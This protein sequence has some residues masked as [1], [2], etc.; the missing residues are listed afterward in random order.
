MRIHHF[1]PIAVFSLVAVLNAKKT[2]ETVEQKLRWARETIDT[3]A[4]THQFEP[5]AK[6]SDTKWQV[7][8][9]EG[10]NIEMKETTHRESPDSVIASDGVFG[11]SEDR[12]VTWAFDLA[13][14]LPRFIVAGESGGPHLMI[15]GE[16]DMF[17]FKTDVVSRTLKKDGTMLKTSTWSSPG[18]A[19]NFWIYFDSPDADNSMLVKEL[20]LDLQDA[21]Y[22]C[23]LK[24]RIR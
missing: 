11:L 15:S 16:G 21:V 12:V 23:S 10:C 19:Q 9:I 13:N 7:T 24:A 18:T 20:A 3:H 14:L 6:S 22:Q 2:V 1:L 17:H 8:K 5:P 4:V